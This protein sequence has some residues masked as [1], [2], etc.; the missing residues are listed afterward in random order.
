VVYV[1]FDWDTFFGATLAGIGDRDLAYANAIG[2]SA[3]R[4]GGRFVLITRAPASGRAQTAR[5]RRL[6][7]LL[8]LGL[9][10]RFDDRWFLQE[11]FDPLLRWNRW[12]AKH[13]DFQGYL[14]W[15]SDG[16]NLPVD[17]EDGWSGK[18]IGAILSP[19]LDNSPM[20]D[21]S[22]YNQQA[23]VLE[24]ADVGLMS[25]TSPIAMR[26]QRS[27]PFWARREGRR[28]E[29]TRWAL[30]RKAG[31]AVERRN[32]HLSQQGSAHRTIRYPALPTNFYPMLAQAATPE[33][34]RPW[35][36]APDQPN[37][38]WGEWIIPSIAR[39]DPA[40]PD[41]NYWRGRIWGPMNYLVTWGW[42]TMTTRT[43]ASGSHKSPTNYF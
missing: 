38:F 21:S 1:L 24:Y 11:A 5:N 6:A 25:M 19:G 32:R 29:G 42:R 13:R 8:L 36:R 20:Y 30:S 17:P 43:C 23:H 35:L 18:R 12:W 2:D 10:R 28:V 39:N 26:W 14:T 41:Q 31:H 7:P 33:Q 3:R 4:D 15:G 27:R 40:F 22:T 34:A 37:E 16:E 9:Y